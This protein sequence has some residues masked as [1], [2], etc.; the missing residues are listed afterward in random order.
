MNKSKII[1]LFVTEMTE[2]NEYYVWAQTQ[3]KH[4]QNRKSNNIINDPTKKKK[5]TIDTSKPTKPDI[6]SY[7]TTE[8]RKSNRFNFL[9]LFSTRNN[10][11]RLD[12]INSSK[13]LNVARLSTPT[14]YM[15]N[16]Q[17]NFKL[18]QD[19]M[20]SL[21]YKEHFHKNWLDLRFNA[22]FIKIPYKDIYAKK[23]ELPPKETNKLTVI[24]NLDETLISCC[25]DL[26][27]DATISIKYKNKELNV[28]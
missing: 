4:S 14:Y 3:K 19:D 2:V 6:R 21:S 9:G 23:V 24:L 11:K 25:K 26:Q 13:K 27:G 5:T 18:E 20:F 10:K 22:K 15:R 17:L 8:V 28:K 1:S 16:L 7:P 12:D